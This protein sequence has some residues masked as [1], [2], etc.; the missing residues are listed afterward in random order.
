MID[1]LQKLLH[2]R[3]H[4]LLQ[5]FCLPV[6]IVGVH[7]VDRRFE[8][9][10]RL[11]IIHLRPQK[12][13]QASESP[14]FGAGQFHCV[15]LQRYLQ[16]HFYAIVAPNYLAGSHLQRTGETMAPSFFSSANAF[17]PEIFQVAPVSLSNL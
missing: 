13:T 2:Q 10:G 14:V 3:F 6:D 15:E 11:N 8:M 16:G 12:F 1:S 5:H 4:F 9:E 17:S 7:T